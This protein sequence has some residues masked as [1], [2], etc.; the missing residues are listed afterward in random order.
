MYLDFPVMGKLSYIGDHSLLNSGS[1]LVLLI[2]RH[3]ILDQKTNA[4]IKIAHVP[5][6]HE[7]LLALGRDLALQIPEL[8]LS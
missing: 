1:K 4:G 8:F 3:A 2:D 6:K 5:F 7:I